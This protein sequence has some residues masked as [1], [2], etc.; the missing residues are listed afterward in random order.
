MLTI[1]NVYSVSTV[2]TVGESTELCDFF[3]FFFPDA[4]HG[5]QLGR[6]STTELHPDS[7]QI[8]CTI[9]E[10]NLNKAV[11]RDKAGTKVPR[12]TQPEKPW[13][14]ALGSLLVRE[15]VEKTSLLPRWELGPLDLPTTVSQ[16]LVVCWAVQWQPAT[17]G[18]WGMRGEEPL[19]LP[20]RCRG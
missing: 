4:G 20:R 8:N 16:A 15:T 11:A 6:L 14:Q 1:K 12:I 2:V 9:C 13:S 10:L 7:K 18:H 5:C 3:F 19:W 17:G